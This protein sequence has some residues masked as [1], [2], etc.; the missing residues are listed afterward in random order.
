MWRVGNAATYSYVNNSGDEPVSFHYGRDTDAVVAGDWD[1][2]GKDTLAVRR[3]VVT[4]YKN[5]LAGGVADNYFYFGRPDD[6]PLVGDWDGDGKDTIALQR[7][8]TFFVN[9]S[10]AGGNVNG[11][12]F[13]AESDR[14]L[15]GDWDGDGRDSFA[16]VRGETIVINNFL[17]DD[18][19]AG[20]QTAP[21]FRSV[22]RGRLGW[23]WHRYTRNY[24]T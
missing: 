17:N 7:G 20:Y 19:A 6:L 16:L 11:Y 5:K 13:G 12:A 23:R 4:Y 22:H 8:T 15:A 14:T 3:G 1:G 18:I 2:D 10:L 21:Y 9:N 24:F